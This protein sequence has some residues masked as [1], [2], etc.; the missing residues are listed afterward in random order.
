MEIL[1]NFRAVLLKDFYTDEIGKII[2]LNNKHSIKDFEE[3]I[4]RV[5]NKYINEINEYGDDLTIILS[6]ISKDFEWYSLDG[7]G[8]IYF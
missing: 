8:E 6:N 3:E 7:K 4:N 1:E 5:K 2:L